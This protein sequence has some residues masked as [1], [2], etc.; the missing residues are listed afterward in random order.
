MDY[1]RQI[2]LLARSRKRVRFPLFRREQ[3]PD[4]KHF[5]KAKKQQGRPLQ[6]DLSP[7]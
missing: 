3:D 4:V 7:Q 6:T 5:P 1:R 2:N